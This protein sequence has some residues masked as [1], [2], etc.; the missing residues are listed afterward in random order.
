MRP[1]AIL[2]YPT[3]SVLFHRAIGTPLE[4]PE[5][6]ENAD[7]VR[8]WGIEVNLEVFLQNCCVANF[9]QSNS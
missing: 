8:E 7:H 9:V 5:A 3:D 4:W 1:W 2:Q 6:K